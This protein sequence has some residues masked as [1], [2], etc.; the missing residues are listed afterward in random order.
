MCLLYEKKAVP[1][2]E[3]AFGQYANFL[4]QEFCRVATGGIK[5]GA[6]NRGAVGCS[7]FVDGE[8]ENP[9]LSICGVPLGEN[10]HCHYRDFEFI[11]LY[12]I[13]EIQAISFWRCQF[14]A[15][16]CYKMLQ[17]NFLSLDSSMKIE[18]SLNSQ[19]EISVIY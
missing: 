2:V 10:F 18:L 3:K 13:R 12:N 8:I 15:P 4:I 14:G 7:A 1:T 5:V 11:F 17:L 16:T 19:Q 9:A 6:F